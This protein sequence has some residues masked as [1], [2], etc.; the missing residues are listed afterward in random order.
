MST[1]ANAAPQLEDNEGHVELANI[2]MASNM[3]KYI[4]HGYIREPVN[5]RTVAI[6][7]LGTANMVAHGMTKALRS[8]STP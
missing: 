6:V 1:N 3:T 7:S 8:R 2:P 5:A 4:K